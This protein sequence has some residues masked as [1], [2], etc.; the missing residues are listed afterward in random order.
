ML[1]ALSTRRPRSASGSRPSRFLMPFGIVCEASRTCSW[2]CL[3]GA[4]VQPVGPGLLA[5]SCPLAL[6]ARHLTCPSQM[7]SMFASRGC[8][9]Q[10]CEA[11]P[12]CDR[13][14]HLSNLSE[15]YQGT[16]FLPSMTLFKHTGR[17]TDTMQC[18]EN[19]HEAPEFGCKEGNISLASRA[20]R[21]QA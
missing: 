4:H 5:S 1:L 20:G 2:H 7:A 6:S 19:V 9:H 8:P 11:K 10:D 15:R 12:T 14:L 21:T 17:F 13:R 3:R 18:F 16:I